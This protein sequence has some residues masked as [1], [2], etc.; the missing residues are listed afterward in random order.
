MITLTIFN[1]VTTRL[2]NEYLIWERGGS[3]PSGF[4]FTAKVSVNYPTQT[5]TYHPGFWQVKAIRKFTMA[6][7]LYFA[8]LK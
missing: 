7:G 3:P 2:T 8:V 1:I 6:D 5:L 4:P